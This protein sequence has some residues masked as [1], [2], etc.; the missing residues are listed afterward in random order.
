VAHEDDRSAFIEGVL[1][2]GQRGGDAL[3]VCDDAGLLILG[4]IEVD[5]HEDAFAVY[6]NVFD[7]FFH[8]GKF[9]REGG[10]VLAEKE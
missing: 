8:S 4:N 3:G 6:G 5:A 9:E 2:R 7:G 10:T 1:D